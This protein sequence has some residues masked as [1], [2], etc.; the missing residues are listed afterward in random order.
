MIANVRTLVEAKMRAI[1]CVSDAAADGLDRI[2]RNGFSRSDY[3]DRNK[4]IPL[5]SLCA[6][7]LHGG[8]TV[9]DPSLVA[10]QRD[11]R[12]RRASAENGSGSTVKGLGH[13][14]TVARSEPSD[15]GIGWTVPAP[16][17]K[18]AKR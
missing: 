13:P 12:A 5:P 18:A 4:G 16:V 3:Y 9:D 7:G 8:E 17:A 14:S 6:C 2:G 11:S 15:A 10:W 1:H